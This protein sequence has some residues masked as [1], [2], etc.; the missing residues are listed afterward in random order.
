MI[1]INTIESAIEVMYDKLGGRVL[2]IET[3][4]SGLGGRI[5][6][7]GGVMKSTC[8]VRVY[9]D[10]SFTIYMDESK[11]TSLYEVLRGVGLVMLR[12]YDEEL[13]C[14]QEGDYS[15]VRNGSYDRE[16]SWAMDKFA[17]LVMIKDDDLVNVMSEKVT[18]SEVVDRFDL[19]VSDVLSRFQMNGYF[20]DM[21]IRV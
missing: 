19:P 5:V 3:M 14:Y 10:G 18:F 20:L 15:I 7:T 12:T 2:E 6:V 9:E 8:M 13:D 17:S 21:G 11:A 4:M 1:T 16:M